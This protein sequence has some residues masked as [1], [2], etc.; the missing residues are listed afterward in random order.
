MS[1]ELTL[2]DPSVVKEKTNH[3]L[4][5]RLSEPPQQ[6]RT[7]ETPSIAYKEFPTGGFNGNNF[8]S[9][10]NLKRIDTF[11]NSPE[12]KQR[13]ARATEKALKIGQEIF[14]GKGP[15]P[16]RPIRT[17]IDVIEYA[18]K[19]PAHVP[20]SV[21]GLLANAIEK[22]FPN[23]IN[24]GPLRATT[25]L[26]RGAGWFLHGVADASEAARDLGVGLVREVMED[27]AKAGKT[28]QTIASLAGNFLS[29]PEV[30]NVLKKAVQSAPEQVAKFV[31]STIL[32]SAADLLTFGIPD[33]IKGVD[34]IM[35][36]EPTGYLTL[37]SGVTGFLTAA[38]F[39]GTGGVGAPAVFAART[40]MKTGLKGG[41]ITKGVLK[42]T[43]R[44]GVTN[45]P[46]QAAR[47]IAT[48][49]AEGV[50]EQG[51]KN[52]SKLSAEALQKFGAESASE[53]FD[54]A[55]KEV[56][57]NV[58][59]DDFI[60]KLLAQ[61][62]VLTEKITEYLRDNGL[63]DVIEKAIGVDLLQLIKS[64]KGVKAFAEKYGLD[65]SRATALRSQ[66]I[67]VPKKQE[68]KIFNEMKAQFVEVIS[69]RVIKETKGDFLKGFD[70]Q[71]V[72]NRTKS[73]FTETAQAKIRKAAYEMADESYDVAVK[74]VV[75]SGV[76][77]HW[78]KIEEEIRKQRRSKQGEETSDEGRRSYSSAEKDRRSYDVDDR[79]IVFS[80]VD[81][82]KEE[83]NIVHFNTLASKDDNRFFEEMARVQLRHK[84]EGVVTQNSLGLA[85]VESGYLNA[86]I[87]AL[88]MQEYLQR[89][90]QE[91]RGISLYAAKNTHSRHI[92]SITQLSLE[93][94]EPKPE[95]IVAPVVVAA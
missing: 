63:Q 70:D 30:Q 9:P 6:T 68:K 90:S 51:I 62:G 8:Q 12:G 52:N 34:Q 80:K 28:L 74:R 45:S 94:E 65:L 31:G 35:K 57:T 26:L 25:G 81:V 86:G 53:I 48:S 16:D 40:L 69:E 15:Q 72:K 67:N 47:E 46:V 19:H 75:T 82:P 91:P 85:S 56:G 77:K 13:A 58:K 37:A 88:R 73:Q 11:L 14:D 4:N 59:P 21:P 10:E 39:W 38:A 95:K 54:A 22:A 83:N 66:L 2:L 20:A 93:G 7:V 1:P 92:A 43:F 17:P 55:L 49:L 41:L 29:R 71:I 89:P 3:T 61:K 36:G 79:K 84:Q 24:S 60:E 64:E 23:E 87:D 50:V 5:S 33:I 42:Q 78:K 27:P 76:E 32:S 18:W 44:V